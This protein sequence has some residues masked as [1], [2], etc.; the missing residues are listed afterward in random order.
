MQ[1]GQPPVQIATSTPVVSVVIVN[2]HSARLL[3][4]CLDS[5]YA[6]PHATAFE[7]IVVDSASYDGC[8]RML[9]RRHPA[10]RFIQSP[11]NVGFGRANNAG[12]KVARG[13]YLLLLNPDTQVASPVIDGLLHSHRAL[14]RIGLLGCR[15]LN[16]DG[17][18]QTTCVQP[19]PTVLNQVLDSGWL[20]RR[21]PKS[22]LWRNA[23]AHAHE[24]T[25]V[26]VE[27]VIGA[28]MFMRTETFRE[29]GG[30]GSE[31]FMYAEDIALCDTLQRRGLPVY[32]DPTIEV[33]HF[34]G[35]SS[36]SQVSGFSAVMM[37][38]A[39]HRYLGQ[40]RGPR[41]ASAY[42]LAMRCTAAARMLALTAAWPAAW[43]VGHSARVHGGL[44]KW[45]AVLAWSCGLTPTGLR[46][47]DLPAIS[48]SP[49]GEAA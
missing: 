27:S 31:Y 21:F 9:A 37:R 29:V 4:Q 36:A 48:P 16:G 42:R 25:P 12:A 18:L 32:W 19:L 23:A 26:P 3:E 41:Q 8:D 47:E 2:W 5:L 43:I 6:Q 38:D 49:L 35:G 45:R 28:C 1:A 46:P 40:H 10:V 30:F 34:G 13:E 22:R 24:T 11:V 14:P 15:L 20:Q 44:R 17:T 33:T 39:I 7:V